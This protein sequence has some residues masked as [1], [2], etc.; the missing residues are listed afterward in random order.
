MG[1]ESISDASTAGRARRTVL[2]LTALAEERDSLLALLPRAHTVVHPAGSRYQVVGLPQPRWR[3]VVG[4]TGRGNRAAAVLTERSIAAFAPAA[5]IF[6][7]IAGALL[8]AIDLGDIVVATEVYAIHGGREDPGVFRSRPRSWEMSHHLVQLAEQ[9]GRDR[10]WHDLL[11]TPP[12]T[13]PKTHLAP[14]AAGDVVLNDG[15]SPVARHIR[16]RYNDAAA[17][18]TESAG[19]AQAAHLNVATP[20]LVVRGISD[21]A[22]GTKSATDRAGCRLLAA[23]H[24]AAFAY[25]VARSVTEM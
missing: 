15:D 25:A 16:D 3:L 14:I 2:V 17:I 6:A 20:T 12:A 7:G 4:S 5:V 13:K 24:A 18:D 10:T 23:E 19:V 8:P 21:S 11:Q 1:H 9:L 22:D